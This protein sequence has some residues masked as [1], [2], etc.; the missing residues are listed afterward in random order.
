MRQIIE[1]LFLPVQMCG[2]DDAVA[3]DLVWP[4]SRGRS[5]SASETS[6]GTLSLLPTD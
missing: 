3:R 4:A 2:F 5:Y 6:G 1:Q